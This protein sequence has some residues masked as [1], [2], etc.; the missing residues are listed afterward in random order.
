MTENIP[1]GTKKT[2]DG[3]PCV[4]YDGYWIR[5]YEVE[6]DDLA[7]K[8]KMIDQ[9][10]KRVFHHCEPGINTPGYRLD[11]IRRIYEEETDPAR[12]RVKG[13]MLAGALLN[14]GSDILTSVVDLQAAGVKVGSCSQLLRECGQCFMEAL[15]MG[16]NIKLARGGEGLDE[17]W[18]EPFKVFSM[19]MEQF[20][21]SRYIKVAQTMS[22]IDRI[23]EALL[24]IVDRQKQFEQAR[25]HIEELSL[26]A[27]LACETI[28]TD[29]VN[30]D[31]WPRYV[32]AKEAMEE[33][34]SNF[35]DSLADNNHILQRRVIE[36][37]RDGASLLIS[38]AT[39]RVPMPTSTE[40]IIEKCRQ[41]EKS[42]ADCT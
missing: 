23:T 40:K 21:E 26:T 10:T 22:E 13:G 9:L 29:P 24:R 32:A 6:T 30:F 31:V 2:I 34:V 11:Q 27:K 25:A 41:L 1:N 17:L 8:K 38:L 15:E 16:R 12:K 4:H 35:L 3:K 14:R 39:V 37:I 20:Y 7:T 36:L 33:Y 5:A 19:S 18:G 28:R 42:F